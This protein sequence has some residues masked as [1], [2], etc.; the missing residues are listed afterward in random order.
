MHVVDHSARRPDVG[1]A[2]RRPRL[3]RDA[4]EARLARRWHPHRGGTDQE[5]APGEGDRP[6]DD[7]V[8]LRIRRRRGRHGAIDPKGD[9]VHRRR[10]VGE[11][12]V[13]RRGEVWWGEAPSDKGRP[14]LVVT[15]DAALP[16]LRRILVAPV[17]TRLRSIP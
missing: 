9:R 5:G 6:P 2:A 14:Y 17:T 12:V 4:P 1:P 15:R 3:G 13:I 7:R 11:V 10:T 8:L 16:V